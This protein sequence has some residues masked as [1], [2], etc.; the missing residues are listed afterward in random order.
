MEVKLLEEVDLE[1][2]YFSSPA[3]LIEQHLHETQFDL[4][5]LEVAGTLWNTLKF[6][7]AVQT[8]TPILLLND[9]TPSQN[10]YPELNIVGSYKIQDFLDQFPALVLSQIETVEHAR[11]SITRGYVR[12][13]TEFLSEISPLVSDVFIQF[14]GGKM[15]R[16]FRQGT[17]FK[18]EDVDRYIQRKKLHYLYIEKDKAKDLV[19]HLQSRLSGFISR[20][21]KAGANSTEV[22]SLVHEMTQELY[23]QMGFTPETQNLIK[24]VM[25]QVV[26]EVSVHPKLDQAFQSLQG[27][28]NKFIS[29]HSMLTAQLACAIA[30][31][32]QWPSNTTYSKLVYAAF[33]HDFDLADDHLGRLEVG[34]SSTESLEDLAKDKKEKIWLHA[35]Q[36]S[37]EL[38]KFS[39]L[40]QDVDTIIA[41]HHEL[42]DGSGY[43]KSLR[44]QHL[45]PLSLVFIVAHEFVLY[46]ISCQGQIHM[47]GFKQTCPALMSNSKCRG[48]IEILPK[49]LGLGS[50]EKASA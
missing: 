22:F 32:F 7:A 27:P 1:V 10:A 19:L 50:D 31:E 44:A 13:R 49:V 38:V 39:G 24:Q 2:V 12:V 46:V 30:A 11:E 47:E 9:E 6:F 20:K 42:P 28:H 41:Q 16:V 34:R 29:T 40:P 18:Q 14:S 37:Q 33:F 48:Y 17:V 35:V 45:S 26:R 5:I 43:P 21:L 36:G 15:I 25:D 4:M 8:K 23:Q 3:A